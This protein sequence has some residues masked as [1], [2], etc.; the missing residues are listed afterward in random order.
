MKQIPSMM[1]MNL[2]GGAAE[3]ETGMRKAQ[4]MA[5]DDSI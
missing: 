5:G 4:S 2:P 3:G 1:A